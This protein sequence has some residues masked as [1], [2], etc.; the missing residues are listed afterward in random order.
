[1]WGRKFIPP[2]FILALD[3]GQWSASCLCRLTP[4]GESPCYPGDRRLGGPQGQ[5]R[6]C[7]K[8]KDLTL[9]GNHTR[10]VQTVARRY[11]KL[12]IIIFR[13]QCRLLTGLT[14]GLVGKKL[15]VKFWTRFL[16]WSILWRNTA[17]KKV[18]LELIS[19]SKLIWPFCSPAISTN[20]LQNYSM[21][22]LPNIT[23]LE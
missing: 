8:E 18:T 12:L 7:R 19:V 13:V 2:S 5:S 21:L 17:L 14:V 16:F 22:I 11:T 1:M 20:G 6:R 23:N 15:E 3:G 4:G 9:G 10:A